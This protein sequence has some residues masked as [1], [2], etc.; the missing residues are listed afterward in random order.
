ML[1]QHGHSFGNALFPSKNHTVDYDISVNQILHY[2]QVPIQININRDDKHTTSHNIRGVTIWSKNIFQWFWWEIGRVIQK[3][4]CLY[5]H[6][7]TKCN[8]TLHGTQLSI[9]FYEWN[10]SC[11]CCEARIC[12]VFSLQSYL[13]ILKQVK[14]STLNREQGVP[15]CGL[16]IFSS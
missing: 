11:M 2:F 4:E 15:C 5:D 6:I 14:D 8:S 9:T 16:T 7:Y 10:V 12:I 13:T 1:Y 3:L